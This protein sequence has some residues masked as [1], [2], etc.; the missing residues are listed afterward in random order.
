MIY[1]LVLIFRN[2]DNYSTH[3]I[4]RKTFKS[5]ELQ[6]FVISGCLIIIFFQ[7]KPDLK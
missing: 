1:V 2:M 3:G 7:N 4:L 5:Q 6:Y